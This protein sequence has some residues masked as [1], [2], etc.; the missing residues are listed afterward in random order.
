ML[1]RVRSHVLSVR[2]YRLDDSARRAGAR[3]SQRAAHPGDH[4]V[5]RARL[6][7]GIIEIEAVHHA[8]RAREI[9][10][11]VEGLAAHDAG[12][13]EKSVAHPVVI[14]VLEIGFEVAR[15]IPARRLTF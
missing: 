1:R 4:A 12:D 5:P 2:W 6:R 3:R 15:E 8:A 13:R 10:A 7:R 11:A 14:E 9:A